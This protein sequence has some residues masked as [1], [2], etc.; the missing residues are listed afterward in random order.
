MDASV[1]TFQTWLAAIARHN[2]EVLP[3]IPDGIFGPETTRSVKSLQKAAGL[4]Q[5]GDID[6]DTWNA[7]RRMYLEAVEKNEHFQSFAPFRNF[8]FAPG[9][10]GTPV[11]VLQVMLSDLA[12]AFP[13]LLKPPLTGVYDE[14]TAEAVDRLRG[15]LRYQ[16][17]YNDIVR[18]FSSPRGF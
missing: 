12:D 11:Y 3:V 9:V 6:I 4:P 1:Y 10:S 8:E 7:G 17:I 13:N 15:N 2:D 16:N 18:L 5:T 14:A